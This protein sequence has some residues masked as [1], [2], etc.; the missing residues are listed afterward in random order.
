MQSASGYNWKESLHTSLQPY[1]YKDEIEIPALDFVKEVITVLESGFKTARLN[2][3]MNAQFAMK[4]KKTWTK[5]VFF[6]P[7]M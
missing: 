5:K 3:F 4:K 2:S 6:S 7:C 1:K